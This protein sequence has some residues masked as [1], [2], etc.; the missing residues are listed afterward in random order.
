MKH[1][2]RILAVL[3]ALFM[4]M[5]GVV[6]AHADYDDG[7]ECPICGKCTVG[8]TYTL[9]RVKEGQPPIRS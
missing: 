7:M 3:M 6:F 2:K 8:G 4:L 5:N 9:I 1:T